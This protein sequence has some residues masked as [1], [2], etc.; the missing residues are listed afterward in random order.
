MCKYLCVY[1]IIELYQPPTIQTDVLLFHLSKNV[2]NIFYLFS[3]VFLCDSL[4][5]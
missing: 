1:I 5:Q 2:V 3:F 4:Y